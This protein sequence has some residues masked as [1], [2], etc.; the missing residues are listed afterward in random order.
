MLN[1]LSMVTATEIYRGFSI[2]FMVLMLLASIAMIIVVLMQRGDANEGM[3]AITGGGSDTFL[4]KN[5]S[6]SIDAFL[7]RWTRTISI[8]FFLAVIFINAIMY[9]HIFGA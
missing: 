9:F 3:G 6:R 2:A 1:L 7:A 4:T 8:G 5:K